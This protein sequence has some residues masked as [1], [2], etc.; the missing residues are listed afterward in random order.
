MDM[1]LVVMEPQSG[2]AIGD[3][4][5]T[6]LRDLAVCASEGR[7]IGEAMPEPISQIER[8]LDGVAREVVWQPV[9]VRPPGS[10]ANHAP[11]ATVGDPHR[12]PLSV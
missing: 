5:P 3:H 9:I 1:R 12:P 11:L 4:A 2:S 10:T 6:G 7:A 8:A